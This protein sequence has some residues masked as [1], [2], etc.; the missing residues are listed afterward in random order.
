MASDHTDFLLLNTTAISLMTDKSN[1]SRNF[2]YPEVY[3]AAQSRLGRY[4]HGTHKIIL[5][6]Y[7]ISTLVLGVTLNLATIAVLF[8]GTNVGQ[9]VRIQ[10][11]NLAVADMLFAITFSIPELVYTPFT[12]A[13]LYEM[14]SFF[15]IISLCCNAGISLE[16]FIVVY[17]PLRARGYTTRHKLLVVGGVWGFGTA[18]GFVYMFSSLEI[19]NI[20]VEILGMVLS[21]IS[22]LAYL[23]I[24][25][26]VCRRHHI[27]ERGTTTQQTRETKQRNQVSG[28]G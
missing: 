18:G 6:A 15:S 3:P 24:M 5:I 21:V 12:D 11:T 28:K 4:Y 17:F 27:G 10:L 1:N 7:Y 22:P 20:V 9:G 13:V 14:A 2:L 25:I 23:L 16:R 8:G 19:L 26:K